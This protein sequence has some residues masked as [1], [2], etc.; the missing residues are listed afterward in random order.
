MSQLRASVI[1]PEHEN[2]PCPGGALAGWEA[3]LVG[4]L[5]PR[6]MDAEFTIEGEVYQFAI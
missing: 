3:G 5:W 2:Y 1:I 6:V 4:P